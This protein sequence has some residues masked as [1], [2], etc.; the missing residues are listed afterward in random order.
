MISI[1]S[2]ITGDSAGEMRTSRAADLAKLG[3]DLVSE[4]GLELLSVLIHGST[5]E[6]S[7]AHSQQAI[8]LTLRS[9]SACRSILIHGRQYHAKYHGAVS[10]SRSSDF[11]IR[12]T[13]WRVYP[14]ASQMSF[15]W[16]PSLSAC[17]IASASSRRKTLVRVSDSRNRLARCSN[18]R[19]ST[20]H[21]VPSDLMEHD[22]TCTGHLSP[23][24]DTL[25]MEHYVP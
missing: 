1:T 17:R 16:T 2:G 21:S 11:T 4:G 25:T 19:L 24:L 8:R 20:T 18:D 14:V 10:S 9:H 7:E 12:R 13:C 22:V 6:R 23:G 15:C 5:G 3:T